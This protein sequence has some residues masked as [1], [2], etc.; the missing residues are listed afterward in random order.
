MNLVTCFL[1]IKSL[2]QTFKPINGC[3][4]KKEI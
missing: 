3:K 4:S 1:S 2:K